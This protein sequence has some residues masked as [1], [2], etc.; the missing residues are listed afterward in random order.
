MTE[1][2]IGANLGFEK[3]IFEAAFFSLYFTAD[4]YPNFLFILSYL[5]LFVIFISLSK[6]FI[7]GSSVG[8]F[9]I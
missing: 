3:E 5:L 1:N 4:K 8:C 2:I 9:D 7:I 6:G